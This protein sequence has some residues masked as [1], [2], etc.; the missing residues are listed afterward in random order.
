MSPNVQKRGKKYYFRISVPPR[1]L[2]FYKCKE[3]RLALNTSN[4]D[5]AENLCAELSLEFENL[6]V[7]LDR[8]IKYNGTMTETEI[9]GCI[10]KFLPMHTAGKLHPKSMHEVI[11]EYESTH[12]TG[13]TKRS[14]QE[15]QYSF[16]TLCKFLTDGNK[17]GG[18]KAIADVTKDHA[19]RFLTFLKNM[20]AVGRDRKLHPKTIN[21]HLTRCGSLFNFAVERDI[22]TKN[23]FTS[24]R[25]K[26][27]KKN[28]KT[29][30]RFHFTTLEHQMILDMVM[31]YPD[32]DG[33]LKRPAMFWVPLLCMFNG[34]RRNEA[35][36]LYKGD[37]VKREGMHCIVV[38]DK[39]PDQHVKTDS[40]RRTIPIHSQL[41]EFGFLEYVKTIPEGQRIF[42]ELREFRDGYGHSF[43]R[44]QTQLRKL[45]T[46]NE[47]KVMHS[48]RHMI[49]TELMEAN[50]HTVWRAD[51]L[52]HERGETETDATY[53]EKS[54]LA[55]LRDM[56]EH[57][58]YPELDF[59]RCYLSK[60]SKD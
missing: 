54:K 55:T 5:R 49:S 12:E 31:E 14:H 28:R 3:V 13:W 9:A 58:E 10:E 30:V 56:L 11:T 36:Q 6:A 38:T 18:S 1:F 4:K 42:P 19:G 23:P 53:T 39:R 8:H 60:P 15:A 46:D 25:L 48:F 52:G 44:F 16:M 26:V 35:C 45:V 33:K 32:K 7:R 24:I 50:Q 51:L 2:P 47:G 43:K 34:L 22:I 27:D 59:S 17:A 37:I 57:I 40:S 20:D 41:V 29:R 21:K